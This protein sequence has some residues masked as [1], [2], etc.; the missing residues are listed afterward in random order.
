MRSLAGF[1]ELLRSWLAPAGDDAVPPATR[2]AAAKTVH[3]HWGYERWLVPEGAPF[4]FKL[5]HIAAG[6]RTSLQYH[7]H[8]EEA[9]LIVAGEAVLSYAPAP[10]ET[11]AESPLR[12]GDVVHVR[13]GRVHR[14]T[15]VTDV[16]LI[17]VST[18][19][20]DDVIRLADD[21]GRAD[22]RIAAEHDRPA[23]EDDPPPATVRRT[24]P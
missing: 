8:K 17:E 12:A 7:R 4:G 10:G 2:L 11:P 5:I 18:P 22:G 21:R 6:R 13:P 19:E 15:A 24:R 9:N 16:Y 14:I 3:K 1:D 23:A 20:L